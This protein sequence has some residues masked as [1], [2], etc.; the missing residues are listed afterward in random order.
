MEEP[1]PLSPPSW[2]FGRF[3]IA[4]DEIGGYRIP[5]GSVL[6]LS[7][8]VTHRR[9]ELWPDPDRFGPERFD[10]K[11][12]GERPRFAYYPFGGRPR[13]CIARDMAL[14]ELPLILATV[15][16]RYRLRAV[17]GHAVVPVQGIALRPRGGLRMTLADAAAPARPEPLP[18]PFAT[19]PELLLDEK[20]A[21]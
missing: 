5:A 19:L 16:Q 1:L 3:T 21:A 20:P 10:P 4:D 17:A 15:A 6:T 2:G 14:M 7:P 13:V 11:R 18:R 12:T 9:P 8:W